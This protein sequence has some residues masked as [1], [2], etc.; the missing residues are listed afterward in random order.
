[1]T[2]FD[3]VDDQAS[4]ERAKRSRETDRGGDAK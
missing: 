4:R 1:M 2:G 3:R